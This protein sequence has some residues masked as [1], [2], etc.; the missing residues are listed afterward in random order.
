MEGFCQEIFSLTKCQLKNSLIWL[1]VRETQGDTIRRFEMRIAEIANEAIDWT[2][3]KRKAKEENLIESLESDS[4]LLFFNNAVP[5]ESDSL[6]LFFN[7][8]VPNEEPYRRAQDTIQMP[9]IH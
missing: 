8:A 9:I 3:G 6:L 4:L 2:E 1:H 7:N 5:N